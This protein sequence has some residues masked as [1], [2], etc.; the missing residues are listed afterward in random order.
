MPVTASFYH[1]PYR[2]ALANETLD[3][4]G[5]FCP[6]ADCRCPLRLTRTTV[7]RTVFVVERDEHGVPQIVRLL[8]AIAIVRSTVCNGRFRL[9]PADVLPRKLYSLE[10]IGLLVGSYSNGQLSL[11]AVVW[12]SL[13]G[14]APAHSTLHGWTEG[15]G[16]YVLGRKVGEVPNALPAGRVL[17]EVEARH[18]EIR[19]IRRTTPAVS[20]ARY[21]SEA[22]RD[23]LAACRI[24]ILCALAIGAAGRS[25]FAELNRLV[26]TWCGSPGIG[27]RTGLTSTAIEQVGQ[28]V[29][30]DSPPSEAT[31][32]E[33]ARCTTRGRSPPFDLPR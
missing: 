20:P 2:V 21:R 1:R 33:E 19:S 11:R 9:L 27:F 23:R 22:R 13:P 14:E 16:A 5:L 31:P 18:P 8:I 25:A 24:L 7:L 32:K 15:A 3:V 30:S 28:G 6:R 17:A 4:S 10:V 12:T 26:L 29:M